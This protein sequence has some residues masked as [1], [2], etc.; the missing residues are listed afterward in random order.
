MS[1]EALRHGFDADFERERPLPELLDGFE[2][3]R[4]GRLLYE[5]LGPFRL[6][7]ADGTVVL[8]EGEPEGRVC[9]EVGGQLDPV[10]RLEA[11]APAETADQAAGWVDLILH[12]ARRYHMAAALHITTIQSDFEAL[13]QKH[14]ELAESE[15]RYRDLAEELEERVQE[16]VATIEADRRRLYQ[17]EKLVAVGQLAAGVAHEINNPIGFIASNLDSAGKYLDD[18]RAVVGRYV[19]ADAEAAK[20]A[21]F[22][23]DDFRDLLAESRDGA[24][25]IARIVADLKGISGVDRRG[26]EPID[27]NELVRRV[28]NVAGSRLRERA[29]IACEFG[30]LPTLRLQTGQVAQAF[31]NILLN[32]GQALD[33]GG[34]IRVRTWADDGSVHLEV[35]DDGR[36]MPPE[37]AARAFEPFFT[38]HGVGEG[39]GLGL[40]VARDIVQAHGGRI[41]LTSESGRGSTFTIVLPREGN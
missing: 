10:G 9:R 37:E 7:A 12:A 28:C 22:V 26:E 15:A 31:L 27:P 6:V 11:D 18:L 32:A 16:Q 3:E 13:E 20:D 24:R 8:A 35:E 21:G 39:M 2:N 30:S 25:R 5:W 14:R 33:G 40:T 41:D 23:L 36:G 29:E 19:P 17:S 38:T 4:L 34:T 1:D